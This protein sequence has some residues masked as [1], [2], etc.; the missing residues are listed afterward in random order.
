MFPFPHCINNNNFNYGYYERTIHSALN[1]FGDVG[2]LKII[3]K[4]GFYLS[5]F[6]SSNYLAY[7]Q[8][9]KVYT[10]AFKFKMIYALS[11]YKIRRKIKMNRGLG[12]I[13]YELDVVNFIR[14]QLQTHSLLKQLFTAD[15]RKAASDLKSHLNSD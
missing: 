13:D 8:I 12:R 9:T 5:W 7:H 4:F 3:W 6:V 11:C 14:F 2:G 15:K 1:L 10:I